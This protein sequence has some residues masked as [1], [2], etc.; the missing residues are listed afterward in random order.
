[1]NI[2]TFS[3]LSEAIEEIEGKYH[4]HNQDLLLIPPTNDPYASDRKLGDEPIGLTGNLDLPA[5]VTG[6]LHQHDSDSE[7]EEQVQEKRNANKRKWRDGTRAFKDDWIDEKEFCNP[8]EDFPQHLYISELELYKLYFDKE[9]EQLFLDCTKKCAAHN[10]YPVFT[11]E[12]S[13]LWDFLTI[14]TLSTFSTCPQ[15]NL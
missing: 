4:N 6:E 9:V 12:T 15:F 3:T 10:N 7:G 11:F 2:N 8:I 14:P 5:D 1:M 13:D